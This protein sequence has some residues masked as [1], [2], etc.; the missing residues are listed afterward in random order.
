MEE[1][2]LEECQEDVIEGDEISVIDEEE[3]L[4]NVAALSALCSWIVR[5]QT[6]QTG[7]Q[8]NQHFPELLQ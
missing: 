7:P 8:L 3:I 5:V 6:L 2:S 4:M 1:D